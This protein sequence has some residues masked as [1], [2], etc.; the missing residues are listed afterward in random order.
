MK[1]MKQL[2]L[3]IFLGIGFLS[4]AQVGIGTTTPDAS[5]ILELSSTT[6]GLLLPRM[7]MVQMNAIPNPAEG[8]VIYCTD[9]TPK[10]VYVYNGSDYILI[11]GSGIVVPSVSLICGN[12]SITGTI[13]DGQA[14]SGAN[15]TIPYLEGNGASYSQVTYNSTGVTGLTATLSSGVLANGAGNLILSI[16]GVP[17]GVGTANF[18]IDGG[19]SSTACTIAVAVSSTNTFSDV[20]STTGKVWMDR[21]LGATQVATSSTDIAAYGDMYQWGRA[22]DG[23]EKRNSGTT[24]IT[25]TSSNPGHGDFI[26]S[27]TDIIG[28][29]W[30][31]FSGEDNLWQGVNGINNPCPSGYRLPTEAEWNN[32][33]QSFAEQNSNGAMNSP[34]KLSATGYR[35]NND[36]Q[37]LGA[38]THA[39]YWSS[40]INNSITSFDRAYGLV[41]LNNGVTAIIPRNRSTGGAVRCIKN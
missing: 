34:L 25:A 26:I 38:G 14:V 13:L 35:W 5:S 24:S 8:L 41:F 18:V 23:H 3:R 21:N 10:G 7:T 32:E 37:I 27:S 28:F 12:T 22:E 30:T 20:L 39:M 6:G 11:S 33:M 15:I 29:N 1:I 17:S 19:I 16:T 40:T 9:C 36:G 2:V 31:N 4:F